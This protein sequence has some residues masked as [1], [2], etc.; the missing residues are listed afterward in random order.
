MIPRTSVL[1]WMVCLLPAVAAAQATPDLLVERLSL[2]AAVRLAVA[3]NRQL[4]TARLQVEKAEEELAVARTRRLPVF[5]TE[6]QASQLITPVSFG[7]PQGAFGDFPATGPIPAA[8]TTV[9]VPRQPAFYVTS[10]VA[11]PL[12]QLVQAGL[13]VANA[14]T[15]RD[16]ERERAR[17]RQL[18]LVNDVKRLYFALLQTES[19]LAAGRET[20][21]LYRE[22]QR[23]VQ[24]RL[25]QRV[26][27]RSDALDVE[28][29]LA[30]EELAQVQRQNALTSQKEQLNQLL[31]RDVRTPFEVVAVAT[32]TLL[33][34]DID[35]AQRRALA[36]RPD[37][38][39]ARLTLR[40]AE[41]S[42]KLTSA[43]RIPD[44]SVAVGYTSHFNVDVMPRNMATVGV[45]VSW[46][47]FDWG[48][49]ARTLAAKTHTVR[50]ASNNVREAE[51]RAVLEINSR[52]RD[53]T[54]ARARLRVAAMA[55]SAARERLRVKTNQFQVQAALL[56]DVLQVRADVASADDSYQQAL[57]AFWT[58]KAEFEQAIGE[59]V[60]P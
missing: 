4:E 33:D 17:E 20:V 3:H 56:P 44:V 28:F 47:P 26:A 54:E 57:L 48:R 11:Q 30:Q 55:Q 49:K 13:G 23:T 16:L 1:C 14:A 60:I 41:I 52:F 51:D 38:R 6:V 2:D 21:A 43:D 18:S 12:T 36:N 25:V 8:D 42:R 24:D 50:Q 45:Q 29:R 39:E 37:I 7:F 40:Q 22:L 53:L 59:E 15:T 9:T 27:L 34:V 46:E 35:A 32:V 58:A 5:E 10:Q 31:G 19:A